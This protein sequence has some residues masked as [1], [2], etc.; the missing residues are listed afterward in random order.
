MSFQ[1]SIVQ[2]E[3]RKVRRD[4]CAE[5]GALIIDGV[6]HGCD[7]M[8]ISSKGAR[9]ALGANFALPLR[10]KLVFAHGRQVQCQRIWQDGLV[11][12]VQFEQGPLWKRLLML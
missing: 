11:A 6:R 10:L 1:I 4:R 9:V 5:R 3:R 7:V 2:E 8:E 12:G